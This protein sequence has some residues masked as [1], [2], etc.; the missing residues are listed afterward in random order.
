MQPGRLRFCSALSA[1]S[2]RR[3]TY[4]LAAS[5]VSEGCVELLSISAAFNAAPMRFRLVAVSLSYYF[6]YSMTAITNVA[7]L[8]VSGLTEIGAPVYGLNCSAMTPD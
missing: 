1:A 8:Q 6:K 5:A 3:A 7:W 2:I 4:Q